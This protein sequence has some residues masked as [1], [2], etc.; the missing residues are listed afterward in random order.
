MPVTT[1]NVPK[2]LVR[3]TKMRK[4]SKLRASD[5]PKKMPAKKKAKPPKKEKK[6]GKD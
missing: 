4:S 1:G 3:G 2:A 5:P 6:G